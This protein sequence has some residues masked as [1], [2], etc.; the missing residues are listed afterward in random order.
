MQ[1]KR[2]SIAHT[3][4]ITCLNGHT[5]DVKCSSPSYSSNH[6]QPWGQAP[7]NVD[8]LLWNTGAGTQSLQTPQHRAWVE[9]A[10]TQ[11]IINSAGTST[12]G[13]C[14]RQFALQGLFYPYSDHHNLQD[15]DTHNPNRK[16]II[17]TLI[18]FITGK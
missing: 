2:S 10:A 6:F 1:N 14:C 17:H 15:T 13:Y 11:I 18:A 8:K 3:D 9:G 5:K 4:T 7:L 12:Q 16:H